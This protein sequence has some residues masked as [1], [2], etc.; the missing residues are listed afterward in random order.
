[1]V[2]YLIYGN[3]VYFIWCALCNIT[4]KEK[5]LPFCYKTKA[6]C[7]ITKGQPRHVTIVQDG[8]AQEIWKQK[9]AIPKFVFLRYRL[10][11]EKKLKL[12]LLQILYSPI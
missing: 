2:G 7:L 10:S 3:H 11:S 9:Y 6:L 8:G 1:M 12:A 4:F 5:W